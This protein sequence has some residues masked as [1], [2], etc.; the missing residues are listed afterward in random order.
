MSGFRL[1]QRAENSLRKILTDTVRTFDEAQADKYGAALMDRLEA[2]AQLRPP[3]GRPCSAL[4]RGPAPEG[5]LYVKESGH[6]IIY[7]KEADEI[8]VVDFI[9]EVRDLPALIASLKP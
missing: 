8:L 1:S 6:F 5:M 3:H 2:L 4:V 7:M 9:H